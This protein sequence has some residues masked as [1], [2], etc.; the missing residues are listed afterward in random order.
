MP[1]AVHK[2]QDVCLRPNLPSCVSEPNL[3]S[4]QGSMGIRCVIN[5][6]NPSIPLKPF[7]TNSA[8]ASLFDNRDYADVVFRFP[9]QDDH[10]PR[11]IFALKSVLT[12]SSSYFETREWHL[13][14]LLTS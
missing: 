2:Y 11:Y 5:S 1:H 7:S 8:L 14:I 10:P 13:L 4:S 6:K 9:S 3:E 12:S